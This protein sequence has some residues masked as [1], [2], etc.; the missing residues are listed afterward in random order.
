M[1]GRPGFFF[2]KKDCRIGR[3][4][5]DFARLSAG[6][7]DAVFGGGNFWG[8]QQRGFVGGKWGERLR[9]SAVKQLRFV[10]FEK[11]DKSGLYIGVVLNP[12]PTWEKV[13][14]L[15]PVSE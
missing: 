14:Q 8:E 13:G 3:S 2:G 15:K 9:V 7:D 1:S 5:K 6:W 10:N 4:R 11:I 12:D